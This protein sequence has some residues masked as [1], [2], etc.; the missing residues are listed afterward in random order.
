MKKLLFFLLISVGLNAQFNYQAIV[1]HSSGQV[2]TNNVVSFKFS[3]MYQSANA[4]PFYVEEHVVTAP[5][6]GV[7]NFSVGGGTVVNGSI[8]DIDWS[9]SVFMKE[10]LDTGSG[11]QDMGTKQIASV[12]V[13]EYA[14]VSNISSQTFVTGDSNIQIGTIIGQVNGGHNNIAI[15]KNS[16]LNANGTSR[17]ISIG[18]DSMKDN[19]GGATNVSIGSLSLSN[20]TSGNSNVSIGYANSIFNKTGSRNVNIGEYSGYNNESGSN[21]VNIGYRA[22]YQNQGSS[23]VNHSNITTLG[24]NTLINGNSITNS[25]AIG[26]N[27]T[28]TS[29]NTIQLGNADVTLVNT[30]GVISAAGLNIGGIAITSTASELNLL[31]GVSEIGVLASI[32]ENNNTGVRLSSSNSSNHGD[33]G[34]DA[35]DLSKQGQSSSIRGATGYGSFASGYNTTASEYYSTALGSYTVASGY[36]S[37]AMGRYTT[38]SGYYSVTMGNSTT[39]SDWGS[40]VIGRYNLSSSSATSADSFSTSNPAFVIGNGSAS[41]ARSDAFKVM[42]N[43]DTTTSGIVSATGFKGSGDQLTL[44]DNGTITSLMQLIGDLKSEISALQQSNNSEIKSAQVKT[45]AANDVVLFELGVL[46][47]S[48]NTTYNTIQVK[49][50]SSSEIVDNWFISGVIRSGG[51][52]GEYSPTETYIQKTNMTYGLGD[53]GGYNDRFTPIWSDGF[54]SL[55]EGSIALGSTYS[56]FEFYITPMGSGSSTL[57]DP[58]PTWQLRGHVDGYGQLT[59]TCIHAKFDGNSGW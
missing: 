18:E 9:Q 8:S 13:A 32:S 21:N 36:G 12:P 25:T 11:Y 7:I 27:A 57:Y 41:S 45:N 51:S 24:A 1:R 23:S 19:A 2:I 38:A 42:Y 16:L 54:T 28:V 3:L 33:I 56:N 40:L 44:N 31:D 37:T 6:D 58:V 4:S 52:S 53:G 17:N 35:V 29:S 48:W 55:M 47:F 50:S 26:A 34:G 46:R 5:S 14:K 15:G 22:N 39:A 49:Q 20:N 10:E 59:V 43:G 30:A